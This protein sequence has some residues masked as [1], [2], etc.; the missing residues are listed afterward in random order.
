[1]TN[2]ELL[3]HFAFELLRSS[4]QSARDAYRIAEDMIE[5]RQEILNRWALHEAVIDDG[6]EHLNLTVRSENCLKAEDIFTIKQLTRCTE[7]RLLK[8]PNLG[9][10][11]VNEIIECLYAKGLK[12]RGQE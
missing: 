2:E 4:Q 12:L 7:Q 10:K 11:R 8:T 6:I 9:R 1:M 5:R 3:D